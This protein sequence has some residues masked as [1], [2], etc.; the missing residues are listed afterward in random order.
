MALFKRLIVFIKFMFRSALYVLKTKK[1][2]LMIGTSTPLTV[3]FPVLVG[4]KFRRVPYIL[5]VRDLWP[6]VPAQMDGV[7][8]K[9]LI[10]FLY[11]FEK[12]IYK[13]HFM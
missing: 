5:E 2:D 12:S 7:K 9:L 8:N 11:R 10:R 13:I 6:E 1:P 4:K 3:G